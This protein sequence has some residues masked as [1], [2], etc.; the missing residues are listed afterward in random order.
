M[1]A[2]NIAHLTLIDPKAEAGKEDHLVAMVSTLFGQRYAFSLQMNRQLYINSSLWQVESKDG[3]EVYEGKAKFNDLSLMLTAA[4]IVD[5]GLTK[6]IRKEY[7]EFY[8][9][10]VGIDRGQE[11]RKRDYK[12]LVG[13]MKKIEF[14][15]NR[16]LEYQDM[17]F[18]EK[19]V[20]LVKYFE[21]DKKPVLSQ[22]TA[23][24][25]TRQ[26]HTSKRPSSKNKG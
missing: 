7:G 6:K 16:Y 21:A 23:V 1:K 26:A 24:F 14:D 5:M 8:E 10:A 19:G 13:K 12:K 15:L 9:F 17:F 11:W 4:K 22:E 25:L 18:V 20:E 2:D 3:L